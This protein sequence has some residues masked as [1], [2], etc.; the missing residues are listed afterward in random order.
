MS[1][2]RPYFVLFF[3]SNEFCTTF[4]NEF[5]Y[6]FLQSFCKKTNDGLTNFQHLTQDE[7]K[8]DPDSIM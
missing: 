8:S 7:I 6:Y 2:I 4:F 3:H 5:L 1:L